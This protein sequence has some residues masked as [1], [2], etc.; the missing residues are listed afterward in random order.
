MLVKDTSKCF[1]YVGNMEAK[2]D[3]LGGIPQLLILLAL[4]LL[5][6]SNAVVVVLV[7]AGERENN[8]GFFDNTSSCKACFAPIL[9]WLSA[10]SVVGMPIN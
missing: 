4:L 6:P 5:L 9:V 3:E 8:K 2:R 1:K 10:P 7:N